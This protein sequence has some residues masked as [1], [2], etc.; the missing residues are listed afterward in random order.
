MTGV[1]DAAAPRYYDGDGRDPVPVVLEAL[2]ESG[3]DDARIE[4]DDLAGID[5][6]HALGRRRLWLLP[7]WRA[8]SA[9]RRSP[10]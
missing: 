1:S 8:S 5:E 4:I 6:F 7:S 2:R 9:V 3:R 10:T